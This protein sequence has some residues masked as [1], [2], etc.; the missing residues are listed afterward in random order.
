[1]RT[2]VKT[3]QRTLSML[4][5]TFAGFVS[6]G[7]TPAHALLEQDVL[8]YQTFGGFVQLSLNGGTNTIF[9]NTR[10]FVDQATQNGHTHTDNSA[11][12]GYYL[13]GY[14]QES[15]PLGE[16]T[17]NVRNYFAFDLSGVTTPITSATVSLWNGYNGFTGNLN[18]FALHGLDQSWGFPTLFTS[19]TA[20]YDAIAA[21]NIIGSTHVDA[22]SNGTNVVV[23]LNPYG[24]AWLNRFEGQGVAIGGTLS[25]VP[26]PAGLP[27]FAF[28][29]LGM[30][31]AVQFRKQRKL[32]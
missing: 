16:A 30:F 29:V 19:G 3:L 1:M 7:S 25:A 9:A 12:S 24:V 23:N 13:V 18:T 14:N 2:H 32:A 26:L 11:G 17:N 8:F 22:T 28:A 27:M 15:T 4:A 10:G 21:S 20:L 5:L 6:A 31:A